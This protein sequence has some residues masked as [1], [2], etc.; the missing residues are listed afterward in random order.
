MIEG[1]KLGTFWGYT[2]DGIWQEDEIDEIPNSAQPNAQ[3]GDIKIVDRTGDGK[4]DDDDKILVS[5]FPKWNGSFNASVRYKNVDFSMDIYT[6]QGITKYN[7]FLADYNYGG[8]MR[9]VFNG[10]K[11]NYWTPENP[12]GNF[13][14]HNHGALEMGSIARSGCLLCAFTEYNDRIYITGPLD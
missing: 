13:R 9:A 2:F 10:V 14:A 8:N 3:P 4:L 7:P 11:V 12:T 5:Q 1:E 6:V